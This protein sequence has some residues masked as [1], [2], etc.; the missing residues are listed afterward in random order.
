MPGLGRHWLQWEGGAET[1]GKSL[2]SERYSKLTVV[3]SDS[4]DDEMFAGRVL[5]LSTYDTTLDFDKL[6]KENHLADNILHVSAL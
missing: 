2:N 3:Q 4:S 6:I 5:F 1:Q